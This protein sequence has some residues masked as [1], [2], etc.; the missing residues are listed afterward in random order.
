[1]SKEK[2]RTLDVDIDGK[3]VKIVVRR[4]TGSIN[5][6]ASRVA[7]KIWNEC[8]SD[9]IMTKKEL[10]EFMKKRNIWDK[11]KENREQE[12]LKS[13]SELEK[14]L[15]F[16]TGKGGRVKA[17]EGKDT[18]IEIREKR[19]ELRDLIAE[20]LSLEGNTAE[21]LSDNVRFDYIVA[22]CTY[23]ENG[24]KVYNSIEDYDEKSDDEIAYAA[25]SAMAQMMYS[26]DKDFEKSLPENKFL[27]KYHYTNDDGAL[28]NKDGKTIDLDGRLINEFGHYLNDKGERVDR[29]GNPLDENGRYIS[30]VEYV[31][32]TKPKTKTPSKTKKTE[33][34]G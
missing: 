14:K 24:E 7:A 28:V 2:N 29:D 12:L 13:L 4:P 20:R 21:A 27:S 6:K 1:M 15:A 23:Y 9:G 3:T 19:I 22:M 16:G 18:A 26:L 10:S 11:D 8:V 32:E 33:S 31:E 34:N 25:A 5:T 30:Q 17:S